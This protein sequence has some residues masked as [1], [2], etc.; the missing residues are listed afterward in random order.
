MHPFTEITALEG[1]TI[2]REVTWTHRKTGASQTAHRCG[3]R[4][5]GCG[6]EY[7][8]AR[9]LP[10]VGC[11]RFHHYRLNEEGL[12]L[13]SAYTT[14]APGIC[15]VGDVHSGSVKRVASGVGEGSAIVQAVHR[16]LSPGVE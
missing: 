13:D 2:L 14:T 16:F 12:A 10:R 11:T 6:A 15:A 5:D 8:V 3:I 9:Q 7:R 4:D 1:D